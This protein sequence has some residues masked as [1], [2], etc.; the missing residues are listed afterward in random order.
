MTEHG[1]AAALKQNN[2]AALRSALYHNFA[3]TTTVIIAQRISSILNADHILMLDGGRVIGAGTHEHLENTL[4]PLIGF[5]ADAAGKGN[6]ELSADCRSFQESLRDVGQIR[7]FLVD[8]GAE[9]RQIWEHVDSRLREMSDYAS[10]TEAAHIARGMTHIDEE[11]SRIR[12]LF[13]AAGGQF[14]RRWVL[15]QKSRCKPPKKPKN[16]PV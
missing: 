4:A 15:I 12:R 11:T 1:G 2:L 9:S 14:R 13:L 16:S 8:A 5:C 6:P 7:R 10:T 3:D